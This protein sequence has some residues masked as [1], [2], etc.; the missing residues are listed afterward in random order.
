LACMA[1]MVREASTMSTARLFRGFFFNISKG[2]K[3]TS[4]KTILTF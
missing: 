1:G 4:T 3:A 2:A